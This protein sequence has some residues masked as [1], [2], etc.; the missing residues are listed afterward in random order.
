MN[1]FV[2]ERY[3]SADVK[4]LKNGLPGERDLRLDFWRG[5]CLVD[6]VIIHLISE[7]M[8]MGWWSR[9]IFAEYTRFAAGGFVFLAGIAVS[10]IFLPKARDDEKRWQ[11]YIA[12]W[13]RSL[14]LLGVH[15][16]ASLSMVLVYPLH[17]Y[18]GPFQSG[19]SYIKDVLL[20]Q[21][22]CDLLIFYVMMVTATPPLLDLIR[23]GYWWVVAVLSASLFSV[24]QYHPRVLSLP[25]QQDFMVATWQWVFATGMLLGAVLPKYDA[26]ATAVKVRI[27]TGLGCVLALLMALKYSA[28]G[29]TVL[30]LQFDKWPLKWG[31]ALR[32]MALICTIMAVTDLFWGRIGSSQVAGFFQRLGRRSLAVYVAHIWVVAMVV[33]ASKR[34]PMLQGDWQAILIIPAVA[35]LWAWTCILDSISEVPK[36]RG[37]EP[38]IGQAFW[39]VSGAGVAGLAILFAL[40]G[41]L[42]IQPPDPNAKLLAKVHP[43]NLAGYVVDASDADVFEPQSGPVPD[44]PFE[45]VVPE[46]IEV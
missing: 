34:L 28:V 37:E 10:Y 17:D 31:E 43:A 42:H 4:E 9:Q 35:L 29:E 11:A 13:R 18:Y 40:H 36:K 22:G 3:V 24:G 41:V 44:L 45:D 23:R 7:G 2:K 33:S 32:Y 46:D 12:V 39:K 6:M 21:V 8:R 15:Y 16:A 25:I 27:A 38:W 5:L 20:L 1:V 14:Y 26:L 19:W 30:G